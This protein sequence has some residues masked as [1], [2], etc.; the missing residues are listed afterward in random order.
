MFFILKTALNYQFPVVAIGTAAKEI[1]LLKNIISDF[2]ADTGMAY[3]IFE[4]L[5]S[6]QSSNLAE[7]LLLNSKMPVIEI[8]HD[9]NI[10]PNNIYIG[11]RKRITAAKTHH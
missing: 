3:I 7:I 11:L 4:D 10:K 8:V 6:S 5:S 9:I 2:P 1:D